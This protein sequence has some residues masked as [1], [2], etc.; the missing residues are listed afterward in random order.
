MEI[1]KHLKPEEVFKDEHLHSPFE[2]KVQIGSVNLSNYRRV[3]TSQSGEDGIIEYVFSQITPR[4]NYYVEF[5]A[6]DGHWLSNTWHLRNNLG[7]TGLLMDSDQAAVGRSSGLVK[8][9]NID[10]SNINQLF[11]VSVYVIITCSAGLK[12]ACI[13]QLL[14]S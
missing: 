1:I 14:V 2:E 7:W 12:L 5:G 8:L 10:S 3:V 13:I 6:S 11:D 4:Q 9:E